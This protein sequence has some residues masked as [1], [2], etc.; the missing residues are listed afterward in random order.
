VNSAYLESGDIASAKSAVIAQLS[1]AGISVNADAL[2]SNY[3]ASATASNASTDQVKLYNV[4]KLAGE[5]MRKSQKNAL[6]G[7]NAA[8]VDNKALLRVVAQKVFNSMSAIEGIAKEN[9]RLINN[10]SAKSFVENIDK[11]TPLA[12][13]TEDLT[14][15]TALAGNALG[16]FKDSRVS[17]I[18]DES[19]L[20]LG[21]QAEVYARFN[22]PKPLT[23]NGALD[24]FRNSLSKSL[25]IAVEDTYGNEIWRVPFNEAQWDDTSPIKYWYALENNGKQFTVYMRSSSGQADV[26]KYNMVLCT[27]GCDSKEG[28]VSLNQVEVKQNTGN[29]GADSMAVTKRVLDSLQVY[30][31]E[32]GLPVSGDREMVIVALERPSVKGHTYRITL[33]ID[34]NAEGV[35]STTEAGGSSY[36]IERFKVPKDWIDKSDFSVRIEKRDEHWENGMSWRT[37][38]KYVSKPLTKHKSLVLNTWNTYLADYY[39]NGEGEMSNNEGYDAEFK[40]LLDPQNTLTKVEFI[41]KN[42][43]SL[44]ICLPT[45]IPAEQTELA[46]FNAEHVGNAKFSGC[47]DH[48]I[49]AT[50]GLSNSEY[51][52]YELR[53]ETD[54]T[55]SKE[56]LALSVYFFQPDT[57]GKW[58]E[59]TSK[60]GDI[61][62]IKVTFANGD[63]SVIP[64]SLIKPSYGISPVGAPSVSVCSLSAETTQVTWGVP[65]WMGDAHNEGLLSANVSIKLRDRNDN[66]KNIGKTQV[67]V[68]RGATS[69]VF[70]NAVLRGLAESRSLSNVGVEIR[71]AIGDM[72]YYGHGSYRSYWSKIWKSDLTLEQLL[73][74][75]TCP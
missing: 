9:S 10:V 1:D 35:P 18:M 3:V 48:S 58:D 62:H 13:T 29:I 53:A 43:E 26:G 42:N 21:W 51:T 45:I 66:N 25:Q 63:V 36:N 71:S 49:E 38:T 12:A 7:V 75:S 61:A 22:L 8:T 47:A 70:S 11:A 24:T 33:G 65:E 54:Y 73:E 56:V 6:S 57:D 44:A 59:P 64:T 60:Y 32:A 46:T 15:A 50:F 28:R 55:L 27:Q 37:R 4:A 67:R 31:A 5:A 68:P 14:R 39:P 69:A 2:L 17:N 30:T 41:D 16:T 40:F 20:N 52:K 19:N 23:T 72:D 74:S 34:P